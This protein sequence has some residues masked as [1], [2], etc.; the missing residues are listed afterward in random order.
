MFDNGRGVRA[1]FVGLS[2]DDDDD[3]E[4]D[5]VTIATAAAV[6]VVLVVAASPFPVAAPKL[7]DLEI[8]EAALFR[9]GKLPTKSPADG[10]NSSMV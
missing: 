7:D 2:L 9:F 10:R 6:V 1:I 8:S 5:D 4:D 3:D